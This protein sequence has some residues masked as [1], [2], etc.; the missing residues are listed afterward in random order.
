VFFT[1]PNETHLW[2][3]EAIYRE[4]L[5]RLCAAARN[6]G[7]TVVLKLHPFESARQRRW[8]VTQ[9]LSKAD[10]KFVSVTDAP[11]SREILQKT[12]CAVTIESTVAFE[13]ASVGI[14]AFLCGW[15]R[16]AYA[17]YAPQF[18]R[19]GVG[20]MLETPDDLLCIP[21]MLSAAIPSPDAASRLVQAIAPRALSDV[22]CQ[23]QAS[24]LR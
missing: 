17:G 12:W 3:M 15:L 14:P 6:S 19:F 10:Q 1:E 23:P 5:P 11:L 20:R 8:L 13:C 24:G 21:E 7:K 2:R 16:H 4:V 18:A 22:L 9:T